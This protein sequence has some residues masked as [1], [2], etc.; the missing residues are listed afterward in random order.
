MR[1]SM[2]SAPYT[3]R[4]VTLSTPSG[5]TGRVPITR[6]LFSVVIRSAS[7]L[8]SGLLDRANDLV[9]AGAAAEIARQ[10][11]ANLF[12]GGVRILIEQR[13]G[14]DDEARRAE[15]A[16]QRR[17]LQEAFLQRSQTLGPADSFYRCDVAALDL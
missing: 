9:V 15:P 5:R 7:H 14:R 3:A 13:L 12:L 10:P 1:G 4:P 16:L 8:G 2:T 6:Y 17:L 11:P